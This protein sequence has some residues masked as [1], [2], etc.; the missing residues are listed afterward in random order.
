M[1]FV[2]IWDSFR[3]AQAARLLGVGRIPQAEPE[4]FFSALMNT[5]ISGFIPILLLPFFNDNLITGQGLR[6]PLSH[7]FVI[8]AHLIAARPAHYSRKTQ[9]SPSLAIGKAWSSWS[10]LALRSTAINGNV[11]P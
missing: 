10:S 11:V 2:D 3:S 4:L 6:M 8:F 9:S 5:T 7:P 1:K